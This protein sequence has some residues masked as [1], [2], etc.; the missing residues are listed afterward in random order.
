MGRGGPLLPRAGSV[1]ATPRRPPQ[2]PPPRTHTPH[3][4]TPAEDSPRPVRPT[5]TGVSDGTCA[6]PHLA[7]ISLQPAGAAT[8]PSVPTAPRQKR[9]RR[10][11]AGGG[12][13]TKAK[14]DPAEAKPSP[15]SSRPLSCMRCPPP[16]PAVPPRAAGRAAPRRHHQQPG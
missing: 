16:P 11:G 5:G 14:G 2:H 8:P 15:R 4:H 6:C 3:G 7:T 9:L 13:E 10:A 12:P 1:M